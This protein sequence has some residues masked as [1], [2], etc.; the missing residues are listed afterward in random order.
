[1]DVG[2]R[3]RVVSTP[4][5]ITCPGTCDAT[6][7]SLAV[8]RL[9][10]I[11]DP[12]AKLVSW[13][14][15]CAGDRACAVRLTG[16]ASVSASFADS[17]GAPISITE[18]R[19]TSGLA[20]GGTKIR[21]SGSGF[22]QGAPPSVLIGGRPAAGA[23]VLNDGLIIAAT[24]V[25]PAPAGV[26]QAALVASTPID[27]SI[28]VAGATATLA[29]AFRPV[30][31]SGPAAT[32]TDGDGLPDVWEASMGLDVLVP[33]GSLD[34]DG[35][36]VTN[37]AEYA[38][39]THPLGFYTRYLAEGATGT[40]F[41]TRISVANASTVAATTLLT[42]QTQNPVSPQVLATVPGESRRH[43]LPSHVPTLESANFGTVVESDVELAA[44]R[45][46]FWS[47]N[48]YGS[49][50]GTSVAAPRTTW[51]LAEGSTAWRFDL[52]Y[53][54]QNATLTA[55]DVRVTFLLPSGPPLVRTYAV[56]PRQRIN[57]YVDQIPGLESTDVSAILEST[58]QVPIIVERAMYVS[59]D[60]RPF[61]GGH[62]SAAVEAPATRW[63]LAEGATGAFFDTFVLLANPT[64]SDAVVQLKYL[65][66]GGGGTIEKTYL[67]PANSR[68][69]VWVDVEDPR[70][71][72]TSLSTVV[73]STN[74]V[75]IIAER[76]M[77]WP[78]VEAVAANPGLFPIVWGEA[79][80][81]PG[82]TIT[83]TRWAVADGETGPA[84]VDTQ[85]FLLVANTSPFPATVRVTLLS[86]IDLPPL[87]RDIVIPAN[88][89]DTVDVATAFPETRDAYRGFGAVVESLP[90]P[91]RAEI[92]V[93]R[94]MYAYSAEGV[95]WA[96]GSNILATPV[97]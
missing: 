83:A 20:D 12:G 53:L 75:P 88:S 50:A 69:T 68:R 93:E 46:M 22:A 42:F 90:T 5:G 36:G 52:F 49:H 55:A 94:A 60:R 6:F 10:A 38:A 14:A 47:P 3:G 65:L 44:D 2:G 96:S 40:F 89:R 54:L 18:I 41:D 77:W 17:N 35:D 26:S 19:P 80:N 48:L 8:V 92:V 30:A 45:Q 59:S 25:L 62:N 7:A 56:P 85:T 34:P 21:I 58:N 91:V 28:N 57:I 33:D 82:S 66:T 70:L 81:S 64:A 13:G 11:P 74:G 16:A 63:F 32:D 95:F 61:E 84:P 86:E 9:F 79:H 37:A 71:A 67:V 24:P 39:G 23:E 73:T 43:V 97:H 87:R 51:Y 78:G 29:N 4:A 15:A 27:V 1:V 72:N 76:A 31:L